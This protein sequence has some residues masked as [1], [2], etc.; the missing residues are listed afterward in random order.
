MIEFREDLTEDVIALSFDDGPGSWTIPILALLAEH[1][2][3]ATFF[4]CGDSIPGREEI[5]KRCAAEGHEI[6]NHTTTHANLQGLD[7][8]GIRDELEQANGRIESVIGVAPRL[9]RPPYF[10]NSGAV[11]F[12]SQ[13]L[14]FGEP[15]GAA[16]YTNDWNEPDFQVIAATI[17]GGCCRGMIVDL[18]DGRPPHEPFGPGFTPG[19]RQPTRDAL[20]TILPWLADRGLRATTVSELL[21]L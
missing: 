19:S 10:A 17:T 11:E 15:V 8:A 13:E 5:L 4:V 3:T 2:V 21:A 20:A 9:F 16:V 1:D 14:G 12:V 18:H 6:G 7:E